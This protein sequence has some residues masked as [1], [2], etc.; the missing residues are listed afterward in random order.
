MKKTT[1]ILVAVG[2]IVLIGVLIY[3]RTRHV[4]RPDTGV[5][6]PPAQT[7]PSRARH[8]A[9]PPPPPLPADVA[10]TPDAGIEA[11]PLPVG[12][13]TPYVGRWEAR[14]TVTSA[15]RRAGEL[16]NAHVQL[17]VTEEGEVTLDVKRTMATDGEVH[18][19]VNLTQPWPP[20]FGR[21]GRIEFTGPSQ[22]TYSCWWLSTADGQVALSMT[23]AS[24]E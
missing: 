12:P 9:P 17:T 1:W 18:G 13:W 11:A 14:T 2:V 23:K 7:A 8:V 22:A 24:A 20:D 5:Y 15:S 3:W 6:V 21:D 16:V 19:M 4:D 10:A